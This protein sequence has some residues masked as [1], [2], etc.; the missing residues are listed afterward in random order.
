MYINKIRN[1]CIIAH[2][3]HGKSTLA[4]RILEYTGAIDKRE[5]KDQILDSMDLERERGITIKLNAV[6]L[7]YKDYI[8]NLIDTPGHVDFTYEVSRSM[9][10]CEG[11]ILIVDAAQGIE[12]QTLSNV[13]LA[14]ENNK[15]I[16]LIMG[17]IRNYD[18]YDYLDYK[19]PRSG[20]ISELI[21]SKNTRS[22]G[23]GKCLMQKMEEY[24]REFLETILDN[25]C[26]Y[27]KNGIPVEENIKRE[28]TI[29][30]YYM[31]TSYPLEKLKL[32]ANALNLLNNTDRKVFMSFADHNIFR[33]NTLLKINLENILNDL[34][35][36]KQF[37][38]EY[39]S[40][41][42][43]EKIAIYYLLKDNNIPLT[44]E[45]FNVA[46][47]EY[48]SNRLFLARR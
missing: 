35:I 21:V 1:F 7:N 25:V 5:M 20:E 29:I 34:E 3:D 9:A 38:S 19:C 32:R 43:D 4:D 27:L 11:A 40:L 8:L 42:S 2:I 12:A 30:D 10:A 16:G 18:E 26:Y 37:G 46:V 23:I 44:F 41:T 15:V 33:G 14:L 31:L 22:K 24:E 36:T 28:F 45:N 47:N 17:Y 6:R 48:A 39:R 13:Y